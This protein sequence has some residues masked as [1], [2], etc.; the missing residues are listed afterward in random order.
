MSDVERS[1]LQGDFLWKMKRL[2]KLG[3]ATATDRA[4]SILEEGRVLGVANLGMYK[5]V[6]SVSGYRTGCLLYLEAS[7]P[8][9]SVV[10][11]HSLLPG[12]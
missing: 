3:S 8:S 2:S 6:F 9:N 7:G 1:R 12:A 11:L 4:I 10:R 5:T